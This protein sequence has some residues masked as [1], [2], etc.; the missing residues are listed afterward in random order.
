MGRLRIRMESDLVRSPSLEEAVKKFSAPSPRAFRHNQ[1]KEPI[2]PIE[3]VF[4]VSQVQC[5]SS[6]LVQ[7]NQISKYTM[8]PIQSQ[9]IHSQAVGIDVSAETLQ[10]RLGLSKSDRE[11]SYS[12]S[13][14]FPNS[15]DGYRQLTKWVRSKGADLQQCWFVMEATGVYYEQLAYW[16]H[17]AGRQVCVLVASRAYHWAQSLPIK[18]KTDQIDARLLARY[19]LERRPRRWQPP[20]QRLRDIKLLLR[21]R[22]QL[23]NQRTQLK[24]R[25]HA[26]RQ[27]WDHPASSL[28]RLAEHIE[29]INAYITQ[30]DQQLRQ[31]WQSEQALSEAI[32]RIGQI[33]GLGPQSVLKVVAETN[34]FALIRN[35]NQ[36]ASYAG[37]DVALDQSGTRQ[38]RPIS[39]NRE[40]STFGGPCICRLFAPASITV[41]C[42][43][44]TNG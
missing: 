10:A 30:I 28:R 17:Q 7:D 18:S 22:Q 24:N 29:Q 25:R 3:L 1:Y 21:E 2:L 36:L 33:T 19:G 6:S 34:G 16:L 9:D 20:G 27:S 15:E 23:K 12:Q 42:R 11:L 13:R 32:R 39:Q 40:M 4:M 35:R 5:P 44:S 43:L 8:E 31:L 37:L 26:A 38:G 41:L 14:R